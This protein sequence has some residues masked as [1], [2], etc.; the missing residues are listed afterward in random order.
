M[1]E[2]YAGRR[3]QSGKKLRSH[4]SVDIQ[5]FMKALEWEIF[6][7]QRTW[8]PFLLLVM[9]AD[10]RNRETLEAVVLRTARQCDLVA[11]LEQGRVVVLLVGTTAQQL[12][13]FGRRIVD[14]LPEGS[15]ERHGLRLGSAFYP[16]GGENAE[17]LVRTAVESLQPLVRQ[18]RHPMQ[19]KVQGSPHPADT[20]GY[21]LV[22]DD[23]P[24]NRR[25]LD[26]FLKSENYRVT[27]AENGEQAL[28][29]LRER[30][31]DLVLL[32]VMMSGMNGF[33]VCRR[34][35]SRDS[36]RFIPVILV[37]AL[38]DSKSKIQGIES[39][40][41]DFLTKPFDFEELS[42]RSAS[43]IRLKTVTGNMTGVENVLLSLAAAV[44]AKD[45]YTQ[46]HT[47]RA[48]RLAMRLGMRLGL[49]REEVECLRIGGILHDVG[50]IGVPEQILNKEGPLS[51]EEWKIMKTHP[52]IGF[53][54]CESLS[55]TLGDAL[56]VILH[57]HEKLD[58][59]SYPDG[60]RGDQVSMVSRIMCA[61]DIYDALITDRPYRPAM[62]QEQAF[63][64]LRKE[65]SEG[66]LDPKVVEILV[67][68]VGTDS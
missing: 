4:S 64:I 2:K 9:E 20:R 54:I 65:A 14:G 40:A 61:V 3:Q 33:E 13:A 57:H 18:D 15:P 68:E 49:T 46:G 47:D 63:E 25:V 29:A 19:K 31:F 11:R 43:L 37:T 35:K 27:E 6:R 30:E 58:G 34:I 28:A 44:E 17:A 48:S 24:Q 12:P 62:S 22:V 59:T 8:E 36:T 21:V 1:N 52:E 23:D 66:K 67:R 45:R 53:R 26:S 51:Q 50:K 7:A 55:R 10:V 39:G 32:D 5:F 41:D 42:A 56:E 16:N 38:D 60:L